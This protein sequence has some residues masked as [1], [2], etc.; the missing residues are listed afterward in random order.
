[1]RITINY[2]IKG[3]KEIQSQNLSPDDSE[4]FSI[5]MW[6]LPNC[7]WNEFVND[8]VI[9]QRKQSA[10]WP[11]RL[12]LASSVQQP[13]S[14]SAPLR[15]PEDTRRDDDKWNIP[16]ICARSGVKLGKFVPASGMKPTPYV[17][18][19]KT[20]TFLHPVFSLELPALISRAS[21]A[22]QLEKAGI[23]Q[24]PM[25]DKQ[26]L[27][28]AMLHSS[29]CIKQDTPGLPSAKVVEVCFPRLIELLGWKHDT[30]SDRVSFPKLHIHKGRTDEGE[31]GLFS[32]VSSWLDLCEVCKD[33]YENTAR[34]RQKEAKRKAY[35]LSLKNIRRQMYSDISLKRLWK[36]FETQVPQ[37]ILENNSDLEQLWYS[38]ESRIQV[39]TAEDIEALEGLFLR[40]CELGNSVSHEFNKRIQQLNEWLR[41]YNDTFEI[42]ETEKVLFPESVGI[43]EPKSEDFP[44]NRAGFLVARAR[45]QLANK[46]SNVAKSTNSGGNIGKITGDDL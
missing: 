10:E 23:R 33:E 24:Y 13:A 11:R 29:N 6:L 32:T 8:A 5:R 2:R 39:W 17:H 40:H 30:A 43:P 1:M 21:A 14:A 18:A 7:D 36:W 22:W 35:E 9:E 38:E 44:G 41:I 45:W 34:T 42:V 19:W 3:T 15:Q 46:A 37:M 4:H 16:L 12:S 20:S 31:F 25:L 26:L 28:L 27:F